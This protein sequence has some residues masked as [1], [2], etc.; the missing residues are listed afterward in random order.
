MGPADDLIQPAVS[1]LLGARNGAAGWGA[2]T[3]RVLLAL[4]A[5]DRWDPEGPDAQLCRQQ[6]DIQLLVYLLKLV[7]IIYLPSRPLIIDPPLLP[8]P[9]F[10]LHKRGTRYYIIIDLHFIHFHAVILLI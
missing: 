4:N 7:D 8:F 2:D 5:V 9:L 3:A 6:F 10:R 1:W